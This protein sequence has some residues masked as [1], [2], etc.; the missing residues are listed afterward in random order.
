MTWI[1]HANHESRHIEQTDRWRCPALKSRSELQ[2]H[3]IGMIL[4]NSVYRNLSLQCCNHCR[5][6]N[7]DVPVFSM[8][9]AKIFSGLFGRSVC[10][11]VSASFFF[12]ADFVLHSQSYLTQTSPHT[13]W[14][15]LSSS[16]LVWWACSLRPL[17]GSASGALG[18]GTDLHPWE[19]LPQCESSRVQVFTGDWT[20]TSIQG[21]QSH[22]VKGWPTMKAPLFCMSFIII[23]IVSSSM[24]VLSVKFSMQHSGFASYF[25]IIP[26]ATQAVTHFFFITQLCSFTQHLAFSFLPFF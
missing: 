15:H 12:S 25:H 19:L 10:F 16:A 7:R 20:L 23:P 26:T 2:L 9:A 17:L 6:Q 22:C 3:Y 1:Q 24:G 14:L 13:R 11:L 21:P 18:L 8:R 4:Q 5:I